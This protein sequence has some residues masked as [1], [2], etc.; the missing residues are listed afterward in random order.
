VDEPGPSPRSRSQRRRATPP[1][2]ACDSVEGKSSSSSSKGMAPGWRL[3][4]FF[5]GFT[6]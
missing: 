6:R 5:M 2:R 4:G 1:A 3:P